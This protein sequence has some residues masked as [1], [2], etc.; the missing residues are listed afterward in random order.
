MYPWTHFLFAFLLGLIFEKL[1][2]LSWKFVIISSFLAVLIDLDHY[3]RY[4]LYHK[5][6]GF[7]KA[8]NYCVKKHPISDRSFLHHKE[9]LFLITFLLIGLYFINLIAFLVIA[10]AYYSHYFLDHLHLHMHKK[11]VVKEFGLKIKFYFFELF[12]DFV[13][14]VIEVFILFLL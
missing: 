4:I 1:G 6:R 14:V 12:I 9:A 8:W 11:F 13:F 7:K 3:F 5:G 10:I 2:Y